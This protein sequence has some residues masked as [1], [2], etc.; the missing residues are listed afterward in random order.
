MFKQHWQLIFL[1]LSPFSRWAASWLIEARWW[2]WCCCCCSFRCL[3][4]CLNLN[5]M[6]IE[7]ELW[8]ILFSFQT[9]PGGPVWIARFSLA[10]Q[11][12]I[13]VMSLWSAYRHFLPNVTEQM[14]VKVQL[15]WTLAQFHHTSHM[16]F[17]VFLFARLNEFKTGASVF[18][19]HIYWC[20]FFHCMFTQSQVR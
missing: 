3:Y 20:V 13:L 10:V 19:L 7:L 16:V 15:G 8:L 1:A 17:A 12:W 18:V 6:K 5:W 9:K 2:W 14:L 11:S 4:I